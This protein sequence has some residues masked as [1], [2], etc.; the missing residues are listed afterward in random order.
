[1][2]SLLRQPHWEALTSDTQEL[3]TRLT[4]LP[5]ISE[6]YLAGG[7]GL[8]IQIGHRF[9]I[10]LDF[11]SDL[12][13]SVGSEQR[14]AIMKLLTD[15]PSL[16]V[17]WDKDGT[18]VAHWR[19][20]GVSFFRLNRHPLTL[21]PLRNKGIRV[22]KIEEIGAMKL[23]AILSRGNRKDYVDLYFILQHATL[24]RLFEVAASKYPYNPAFPAFAIRALAYFEDAESDPMPRMIIPADWEQ[25]RA[26]L[27]KQ[28]FNFGR[29]Q[30]ELKELW[31]V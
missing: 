5:F 30:L 31:H 27:E 25:I 19:G 16:T 6:F 15:D 9:S 23:A 13:D 1:M 2:E 26:F 20:V 22:A 21:S 17:P 4:T 10:D 3:Y 14:S 29:R 11:F 7:T 24:K 12:S 8:A 18:F 28:A